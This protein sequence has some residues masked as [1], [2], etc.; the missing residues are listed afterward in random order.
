[1]DEQSDGLK[2]LDEELNKSLSPF[3]T[4]P[5]DVTGPSSYQ[6]PRVPIAQSRRSKEEIEKARGWVW[7]AEAATSGSS[8]EDSSLFPGFMPKSASDTKRSSWDQLSNKGRER[9]DNSSSRSPSQSNARNNDG[10]DDDTALPGGIGE[11]ARSLKRRIETESVGSI[12]N[13]PAPQSTVL[14]FFG[15]PVDNLPNPAQVQAH[16][17]YMDEYRKIIGG[18]TLESVAN[19]N[20]LKS[21]AVTA[22]N[23]QSLDTLPGSSH[24]DGL[25]FTPGAGSP[26]LSP[27]T[28]PDANATILNQWNPLY[29]PPKT[30]SPKPAPFFS[31]P[32]EIPR[33]KF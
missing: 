14:D 23:N 30:D 21:A 31:P 15:K 27:G 9:L 18:S 25:A 16:K 24:S 7:D 17:D 8:K 3:T 4:R 32:V 28:L 19:Q 29:T 13:T 33:R 1:L 26:S 5:T 10:S 12:F 2:Q 6:V 11:A 22:G 20:L